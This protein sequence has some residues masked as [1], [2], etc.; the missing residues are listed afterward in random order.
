[1][2]SLFQQMVNTSKAH[3]YDIICEHRNEL[4]VENEQLKRKGVDFGKALA[5]FKTQLQAV[6]DA[7]KESGEDYALNFGR[8]QGA[9]KALLMEVS[10]VDEAASESPTLLLYEQTHWDEETFPDITN[11]S[12]IHP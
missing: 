3:A 9:S 10:G 12:N 8:L 11:P 5:K 6:T 7:K 1:M 2:E 4:L